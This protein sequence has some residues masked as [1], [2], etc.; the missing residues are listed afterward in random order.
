MCYSGETKLA[1]HPFIV[2]Q[3]E[4][5]E[6]TATE[7]TQVRWA[8]KQWERA[9]NLGARWPRFSRREK[10]VPALLVEAWSKQPAD[11][12]AQRWSC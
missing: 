2:V 7:E 8:R 9:M 4:D 1:E 12:G 10:P 11:E 5:S 3:T 6:H